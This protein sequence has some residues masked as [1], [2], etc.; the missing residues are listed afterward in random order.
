MKDNERQTLEEVKYAMK[1]HHTIV[2]NNL[3]W[4]SRIGVGTLKDMEEGMRI[5][6]AKINDLLGKKK[7]SRNKPEELLR[8]K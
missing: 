4:K 8:I 7:Q 1:L 2:A 3:K 5:S 6:L